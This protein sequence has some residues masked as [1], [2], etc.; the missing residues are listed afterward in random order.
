MNVKM[1][2]CLETGEQCQGSFSFI[3]Q[4]MYRNQFCKQEGKKENKN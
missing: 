1:Y 3:T 2:N 4:Q